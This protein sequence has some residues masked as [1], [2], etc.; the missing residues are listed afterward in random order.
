M[1]RTYDG[2]EGE[3]SSDTMVYYHAKVTE[4][5]EFSVEIDSFI[6][7]AVIAAHRAQFGYKI[8]GSEYGRE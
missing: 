1:S 2:A 7:E 6:D 4:Y 3:E 8:F 5:T